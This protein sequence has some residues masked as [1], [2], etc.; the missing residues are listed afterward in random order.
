[1][2]SALC[3][4]FKYDVLGGLAVTFHF[5]VEGTKRVQLQ[6][7]Q[8]TFLSQPPT[9]FS[10]PVEPPILPPVSFTLHPFKDAL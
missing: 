9:V 5:T 4:V 3:V 2:G 10:R 7:G 8:P 1:M 6:G